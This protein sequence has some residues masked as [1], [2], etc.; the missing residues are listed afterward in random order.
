MK[1][2]FR[3][4]IC[5]LVFAATL[6]NY[7]D[8]QVLGLLKPNLAKTF[9]WDD[10]DYAAIVIAFSAAYAV[11]Q[12]VFGPI[13]Q[14]IGTKS[15]YAVSIAFWS[16]AAMA[17]VLASSTFGFSLAR[18]ALG[19]G[20]GG[21]F[22]I[23]IRTVAEWFPQ[24]ERSV[25][26]GLFNSGTNIGAIVAP[27]VVPGLYAVIGWGGTF[28]V[29]GVLGFFWL[30]FWWW[31]YIAP[32]QSRRLKPDEL[33][34]IQGD[35][36]SASNAKVP[37]RRLVAFRETWAYVATGI[38]VGPVWWF[39]LFW[40]PDIFNR[41][42]KL[43]L[44]QFGPPLA[45]VYT[46]AA[47]GSVAGGGLSAW[48]LRRGWSVN[49][50]RKTAAVICC[51]STVPVAF[52]PHVQSVWLATAFFA[53]ASAAH[54]GWSATMYSVVSDM[55]P[56][57]A[58]GSVVGLGGAVASAASLVLYILVGI[59]LRGTGVYDRILPVCG[60]AYLVALGIF[61]FGVPQIKPVRME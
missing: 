55:F 7:M 30:A 17:H 14:W 42:F 47:L 22:P 15:A 4:V 6:I 2:G 50:A 5:A 43:D 23:A 13:I 18:F 1:R 32:G 44:K 20:E 24:R 21:N 12:A 27:L 29:L 26:T 45:V 8:R 59:E 60:G 37:W 16:L 56:K 36:A 51:C 61:H 39:Y 48:F 31:L 38:L 28:V 3:W 49:A 9:G 25:A 52:I 34:Y 10:M 33:V 35:A 46:A 19:L 40:L 41:L 53:L 11:G 54:Q 58:V 57:S